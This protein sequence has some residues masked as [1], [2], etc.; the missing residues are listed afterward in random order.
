MDCTINQPKISVVMAVWNGERFLNDAIDSILNQ[1]F[2][3]F[4]FIIVNDGSTDKTEKIILSYTD[5]RI[6]YLK[7]DFNIGLAASLNKSIKVAKGEYIA[8]MDDDD[9]CNI[10][11]FKI[12]LDFMENNKDI[13]VVG[14]LANYITEENEYLLTTQLPEFHNEIKKKI[15]MF[16]FHHGSVMMRKELLLRCGCY[17]EWC[18]RIEDLL[19]WNKLAFL[20][21]F[22]VIQAPLYTWRLTIKG[23]TNVPLS[24]QV[25]ELLRKIHKTESLQDVIAEIKAYD[26]EAESDQKTNQNSRLREYQYNKKVVGYAIDGKRRSLALKYYFRLISMKIKIKDFI[27]I[28][29]RILKTYIK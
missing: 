14:T 22:H 15:P 11:R 1:T 24:I 28:P 12:Q 4:E 6:V 23:A 17:D 5:S 16:W 3:D 19:L 7:N 18:K 9:L 27:F 10:D 8:R 29:L 20:T 21:H 25:K 2:S 13:G 26:I